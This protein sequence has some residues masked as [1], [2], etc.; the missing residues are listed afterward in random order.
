M[1]PMPPGGGPPGLMPPGPPGLPPGPPGM[2]PPGPPGPPG[3][4]PPGGPPVPGGPGGM[5]PAPGAFPG[6]V[7]P[8][9]D[10]SRAVREA[11]DDAAI[12]AA[13]DGNNNDPD[14]AVKTLARSGEQSAAIKLQQAAREHR[15]REVQRRYEMVSDQEAA[16]RVGEKLL[17]SATDEPSLRVVRDVAGRFMPK[18]QALLDGPYAE[19]S[20]NIRSFIQQT[21]PVRKR[22]RQQQAALDS[23]RT[24]LRTNDDNEWLRAAAMVLSAAQDPQQWTVLI[25]TLRQS[26]VPLHVLNQFDT[27]YSEQAVMKAA[28]IAQNSDRQPGPA[29]ADIGTLAALRGMT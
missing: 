17:M 21:E 25:N 5:S 29:L 20:Q 22:L 16:M 3:M 10:P 7:T 12:R 27:V 19:A 23:M 13:L 14:E 1:P 18:M 28:Q 24:A 15:A 9:P 26:G 8:R 11:S 4:M 2:P 6:G